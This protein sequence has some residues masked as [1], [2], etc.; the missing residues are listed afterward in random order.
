MKTK[1]RNSSSTTFADLLINLVALLMLVIFTF[2]ISERKQSAEAAEQE[3]LNLRV[4]AIMQERLAEAR[5]EAE[6]ATK[7]EAAAKAETQ[8]ANAERDKAEASRRAAENQVNQIA[9]QL[10]QAKQDVKKAEDAVSN[11]RRDAAERDGLL[12]ELIKADIEVVIAIDYSQSMVLWHA[13]LKESI[14]AVAKLFPRAT[15][16]KVGVVAFS[17]TRISEY[18]LTPLLP[19]S[20]DNGKSLQMVEVFLSG[21][22]AVKGRVNVVKAV[23][24]ATAMFS[25][26]ADD[27]TQQI[28]MLIGDTGPG[29][30]AGET[31]QTSEQLLAS[32]KAWCSS[33]NGRRVL[34]LDTGVAVPNAIPEQRT[35]FEALG[36]S[37]AH[38]SVGHH[39]HDVV[40]VLFE[41][42]F[43]AAGDNQ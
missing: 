8:K 37:S 19:S 40:R 33:R 21:L 39:S 32:V 9:G 4:F 34:A 16:L 2:L 25:S 41:T 6:V 27:G 38:S 36:A 5:E 23:D 22:S 11:G 35:F 15:N 10:N 24:S 17:P 7:R 1:H 26:A 20:Q 12:G 3:D 30:M 18:P 43:Q 31:Q 42:A 13:E 28:L 14:E 29:E